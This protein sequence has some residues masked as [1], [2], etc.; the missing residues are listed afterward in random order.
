MIAPRRE[1]IPEEELR[2]AWILLVSGAM[3]RHDLVAPT[4]EDYI[5]EIVAIADHL[6][7]AYKERFN[8]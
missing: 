8:P 6:L 1:E 7:E 4:V 3:G 2:Q 5:R